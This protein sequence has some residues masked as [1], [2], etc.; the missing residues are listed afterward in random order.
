MAKSDSGSQF[1]SLVLSVYALSVT[2]AIPYYNWQFAKDNW[3]VKWFLLGEIV[4]TAKAIVWPYY[5]F[6]C[7]GR[8]SVPSAR[9]S[10]AST[11]APLPP[12]ADLDTAGEAFKTG[13]YALA[14]R[15][16]RVL[17]AR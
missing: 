8:T 4:P 7:D 2:V 9:Q 14:M 12:G 16:Y 17:A 6:R 15:I 10:P 13:D 1:L 5:A 3:F 11:D